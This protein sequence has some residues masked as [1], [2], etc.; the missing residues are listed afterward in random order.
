M[1][2]SMTVEDFDNIL[3][4]LRQEY[5]IY[6][7][8][9]W[10][11]KGRYSDTD[12]V[13]YSEIQSL[14]DIVFDRKSDYSPKEVLV[15]ITQTI[16][17]FTEDKTIEPE[18]DDKKILIFLRACDI[19]GLKRFD[20]IY[21]INGAVDNYYK[22]L[23]E[24]TKYVLMECGESSRNCF[25]VSMGTNTTKEYDLF[26]KPEKDKVLIECKDTDLKKYFSFKENAQVVPKFVEENDVKIN[27]PDDLDIRVF[28]STLWGEYSKRCI[29]CGRCIFVCVTC[30]CFTTQDIFYKDN[31]KSG[32]RRRVWAACHV[33][34]YTDMA[35]GHR[36]REDKGDRMRFKMMHKVYD[37]KKRFGHH[38]CVGCGR[39]DD[40]C[41][42]YISFSNCV[43]H[44]GDAMKEVKKM[45][46]EGKLDLTKVN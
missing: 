35:G 9:V 44:L 27:I 14:K 12:I 26:V 29:A 3:N 13:G 6:A 4:D 42:E 18:E 16:L 19:N 36:F 23:R 5:K 28:G 34:G 8:V 31:P 10:E 21:L 2:I 25:C 17:Y 39:C 1:G 32:E 30:T 45:E 33:D 7:P 43:N 22:R 40:V 38:M 46:E 37:F 20:D 15:P 11:G 24:K 41:P